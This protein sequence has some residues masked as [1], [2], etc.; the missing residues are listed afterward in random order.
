MI[1]VLCVLL[2]NGQD[3]LFLLALPVLLLFF[4][5]V[6]VDVRGPYRTPTYDRNMYLLTLVDDYSKYI[7]IFLFTT[8]V[9]TIVVLKDFLA[10]VANQFRTTTSVSEQTMV[11]SSWMIKW[12]LCYK[13]LEFF[14]KALV[15]THPNRME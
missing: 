1:T 10:M 4:Y 11:L 13:V 8:K 14:I 9:D 2:Q 6:H 3:S 15:C 7:W 12:L 5:V